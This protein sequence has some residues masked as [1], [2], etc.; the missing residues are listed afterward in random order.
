MPVGHVQDKPPADTKGA[1]SPL[2]MFSGKEGQ[3]DK[4]NGWDNGFYLRSPDGAYELRI[5][6]QIQA[7]K[8]AMAYWTRE[9]E[10]GW[11]PRV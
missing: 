10:K 4:K 8:S 7:D 9:Y 11:E 6:G 1:A 5:T 2:E 3:D